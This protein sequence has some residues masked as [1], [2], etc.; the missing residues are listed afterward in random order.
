MYEHLDTCI[1][2]LYV[3]IYILFVLF[4]YDINIYIYMYIYINL[5]I[6]YVCIYICAYI[7]VLFCVYSCVYICICISVYIYVYTY[8]HMSR[9]PS[10]SGI[11]LASKFNVSEL[12]QARPG[13]VPGRPRSSHVDEFPKNVCCFVEPSLNSLLTCVYIHVS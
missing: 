7:C 8:V 3:Y 4:V 6:S 13:F 2:I 12:V 9:Q 11:S 1:C 5:R 10:A